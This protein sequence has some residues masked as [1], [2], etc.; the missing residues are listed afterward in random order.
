MDFKKALLKSK[1]KYNIRDIISEVLIIE[2]N[3][4]WNICDS[5]P[6]EG[7]YLVHYTNSANLS[8]YGWIKGIVID[9]FNKVIVCSSFGHVKTIVSNKIEESNEKIIITD[10]LGNKKYYPKN[11]IKI[12][13]GF[14]GT[15][16]RVF[17]HNGNVYHSSH[18]KLSV[19]N[20]KWGNSITF[21]KM[22]EILGGPSNDELFN[23]DSIYSPYC[24]MFILVHPEI[25][26]VTKQDIGNGYIVYLGAKK[27]WN[28]EYKN[29]GKI[30]HSPTIIKTINKVPNKIIEK[31]IIVSSPIISVD[32][33]NDH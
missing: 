32:E 9:I 21:K 26:N 19:N 15:L 22:Y 20:S 33:A 13:I 27:M 28:K 29:P 24:Y 14:E 5:I 6:S 23:K 31:N 11:K 1:K 17:K 16:I 10:T 4:H 8:K 2:N 7:L 3:E 12:N 25:I 18:H 30:K